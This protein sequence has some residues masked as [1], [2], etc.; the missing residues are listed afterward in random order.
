MKFLR[1]DW[2]KEKFTF[3]YNLNTIRC[4]ETQ[5]AV[6]DCILAKMNIPRPEFG[7]FCKVRVH[8]SPRP[9]PEKPKPAEYPDATP[10]VVQGPYP[11]A[12]YGPRSWW[13]S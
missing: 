8:D 9:E 7:Y 13:N 1:T 5:R 4:R 12:K 11:E 3:D 6:D 10:P 2:K